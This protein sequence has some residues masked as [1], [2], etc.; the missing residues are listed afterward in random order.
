[1]R[2]LDEAAWNPRAPLQTSSRPFRGPAEPYPMTPA[3]S[4]GAVDTKAVLLSLRQVATPL[5][6]AFFSTANA[7][8]IQAELRRV[9]RQKTG[10]AIGRQGDEALLAVMRAMYLQEADFQPR[11]VRREVARLNALVLREIV[12]G[13]ASGVL[14]HLAYLRDSSTLPEPLPHGL[15]TSVK[16]TKTT[17]TFRPM[18]MPTPR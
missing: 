14:Q 16:G 2:P 17:V 8:A 12:P 11:D 6:T 15:Q 7:D 18:T 9:I 13:V 1:M 4:A 5:N 10:H 3:P